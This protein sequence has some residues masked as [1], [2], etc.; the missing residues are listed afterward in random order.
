MFFT[1]YEDDRT[2]KR[3]K[4]TEPLGYILKP[5]EERYLRSSI[6]MALYKHEMETR[7]KENER[8]LGTI[9]KSVGDAVVVTDNEGIIK[10]MNPI[11]EKPDRLE[12]LNEVS[13]KKR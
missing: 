2:L 11:A 4:M 3:A 8:W 5:F 9:L 7:L 10:F 6:E 1:A 12:A 13:G